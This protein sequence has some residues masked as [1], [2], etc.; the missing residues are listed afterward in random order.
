MEVLDRWQLLKLEALGYKPE[1]MPAITLEDILRVLPSELDKNGNH[2][3]VALTAPGTGHIP[4]WV[5]AIVVI[6]R[7]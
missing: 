7:K 2:S 1:K 3:G 4:R 5:C 6:I